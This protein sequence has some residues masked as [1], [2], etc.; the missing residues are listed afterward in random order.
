MAG[1][2]PTAGAAEAGAE[3][4]PEAL[5]DA[6][7]RPVA[8]RT[9]A[10]SRGTTPV[11][12]DAEAPESPI[13][14]VIDRLRPAVV[15]TEGDLRVSGTLTN[16]SESDWSD[17]KVY[18]LTSTEPMTTAAEIETAVAS[19]PDIEI[20]DRLIDPGL[21]QQAPD[22]APGESTR[23]RLEVPARR[24]L[25]SGAPGVYWLGV[26][27]LGTDDTGRI[28]GADG[29]ARTLLPLVPQ[30]ASTRLALGMP[31]R[32]HV[33]RAADGSLMY[34]ELWAAQL[35]SGRMERVR[36]FAASA[37]PDEA[38]A[39]DPR[40][41]RGA[42]SAGD[43]PKEVD[44]GW[45]LTWLVDGAVLDAA[46][47]LSAGNPA[48]DLTSDGSNE[49]T[50]PDDEP[51]EEETAARAAE[52]DPSARAATRW[53]DRFV[54]DAARTSVLALPYGDLDVSAAARGTE[55]DAA[56][57][58]SLNQSQSVLSG[59]GVSSA[60]VVAPA[61]GY[62]SPEALAVLDPDLR[63]VLGAPALDDDLEGPEEPTVLTAP[64][65]GSLVTTP[66]DEGI[67]GPGPGPTHGA[68]AVRQRLLA[69]AAVH[70]LSEQ[71]AEPLVTVLPALWDPGRDW[72]RSEFFDAL[73][74]Q[75]WLDGVS[76]S[77]VV[78]P[79]AVG[80]DTVRGEDLVYPEE[81]E[82]AEVPAYA[83]AASAELVDRS[84]TLQ[85][86]LTDDAG[87]GERL[88]RQ[89]LLTSSTWSRT[90][91]G[92]ATQ[93]ARDAV[94]RVDG[95]LSQVTIRGPSF[96]TMSSESGTFQVTL[97]NGLD[98]AVTVGLSATVRGGPLQLSTPDPVELPPGGRRPMR[99]E[100][101]ATDIGVHQVTLQPVSETGRPLG[102]TSTLSVRSSKV[103]L[104]L[105][106]IMAGGA[107]ALFGAITVRTVR[108]VLAHRRRRHRRGGR[109]SQRD[110]SV[111]LL[112]RGHG[113]G[114]DRLAAQRLRP[115]HPAGRGPGH[116][117]ARRRVH[118]RQHGAEHAL[119]P[120]G[121]RRLQRRAGAPA[122]A[123]DEAGPRR[124]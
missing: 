43:D 80:S 70:A 106:V 15:P 113:C 28:E 6:A 12:A 85:D 118:H 111:L 100:A 53:L 32:R 97:V 49:V 124:R 36:A 4:H 44:P 13:R 31:F 3:L 67:W 96:I 33:V 117:A 107:T 47:S 84:L 115:V 89:A 87:L 94:D 74:D 109:V 5:P 11:R 58:I 39:P 25:V 90:F 64:R 116:P 77:S 37:L 72:E 45:P 41:G 18:L 62:L 110:T 19:D 22:L 20:G 48:I 52:D 112:E 119:H 55:G 29:R 104:I 63:V 10:S 102:E 121:R 38:G 57:A 30:R 59:R 98:Q 7:A 51:T 17:L 35:R 24:L 91:P 105:W 46:D 75:D 86:L 79:A 95:W 8:A 103:G 120:A 34:D 123:G 16:V 81:E 114:H 1:A 101:D 122:G 66:T 2:C 68:I 23:F 50:A 56:I 99:I 61:S 27:V 26:H 76:L 82:Q 60:S 88:D 14:V 9:V 42:G 93:R 78:D 65:G 92:V 71:S 73:E 83:V 54:A 40:R 69:E 21:F 108:R